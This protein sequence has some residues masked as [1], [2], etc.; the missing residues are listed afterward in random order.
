VAEDLEI[1]GT[2]QFVALAKRLNAQGKAGRGLWNEL[3]AQMR[4]AAKPM[5]D[6]VERHLADYLPDQYAGVLRTTLTVRVSRST[7]G[8]AAGLKLVG[9][10]KGA[11]KKRHIRVIN[12]GTL[13][14]PVYGNPEAWVDQKV[15]PGFWTQPLA[16][17]REIPATEI[18]RAIQNTIRKLN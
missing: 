9:T 18:R 7:K 14:H 10:A 15:R 16:M 11:K 1:T 8:A 6:V 12:D 5:I 13:R 2:Q 3:N 17:N 4:N